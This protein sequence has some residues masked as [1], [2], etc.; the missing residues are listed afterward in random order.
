M[1]PK[2]GYQQC[3]VYLPVEMVDR[4]DLI[5]DAAASSR[6][7]LVERAVEA[8]LSRQAGHTKRRARERDGTYSRGRAPVLPRSPLGSPDDPA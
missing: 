5:A 8:Y 3:S 1:A 7:L 6:S 2:P 4:L